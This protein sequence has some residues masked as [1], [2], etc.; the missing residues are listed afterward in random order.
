VPNSY[1]GN[2]GNSTFT[3]TLRVYDT[4]YATSNKTTSA[5][6]GDTTNINNCIAIAGQV[7]KQMSSSN[8]PGVDSGLSLPNATARVYALAFGDLFDPVLAPSATF[9][10]TA[11]K[12]LADLG[13]AG[14][15]SSPGASAP[16]EN[17]IITGTYSV[18]IERLRN[19][20]E[21]IFQGGVQVTLVE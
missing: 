11:L 15:T 14:L 12:F 3:P 21:Q 8:S 2:N 9:R 16:P 10:P 17:Q 1:R 5:S 18:R 20:L 13:A 19:C 6:N 7:V 4:F